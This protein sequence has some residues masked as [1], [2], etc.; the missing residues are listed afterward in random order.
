VAQTISK[1]LFASVA[2]EETVFHPRINISFQVVV[3][4][5]WD[6]IQAGLIFL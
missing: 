5:G 4:W 2:G 1:P 6:K 3:G